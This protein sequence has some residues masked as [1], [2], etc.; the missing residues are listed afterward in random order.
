MSM[1]VTVFRFGLTMPFLTSHPYLTGRTQG[2]VCFWE[3]A[4][5]SLDQGL[6]K[7]EN[8]LD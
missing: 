5:T 8:T 7:E 1:P 6:I 2:H 3:M 4:G